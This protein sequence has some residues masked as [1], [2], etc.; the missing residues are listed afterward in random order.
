MLGFCSLI[1]KLNMKICKKS[2]GIARQRMV[3]KSFQYSEDGYKFLNKQINNNWTEYKGELKSGTYA[4]AGGV[5]HNV[6]KLDSSI[7]AHI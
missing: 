6:K 4:Y 7:L 1:F 5:W 3:I 2:P